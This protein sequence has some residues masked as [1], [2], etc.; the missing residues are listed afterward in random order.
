MQCRLEV[1]AELQQRWRRTNRRRKTIPRSSSRLEFLG[2][3]SK[4]NDDDNDN[5]GDQQTRK[6]QDF[7]LQLRQQQQ[8]QLQQQQLFALY[9]ARK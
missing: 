6:Q 1:A 3:V 4:C 7:L 9:A 2:K 8:R 5:S